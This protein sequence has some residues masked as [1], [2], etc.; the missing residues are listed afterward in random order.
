MANGAFVSA[1]IDKLADFEKRS[2]EAIIEFDSIIRKF[3]QINTDLRGKWKG[4]GSNAYKYETDHI[5]EN[6]GGI[7]D[8]LDAINNS[9]VK[10]TKDA[11]LNLDEQ[12]GAFN[13]NPSQGD[14]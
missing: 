12:L 1:D 9:A 6:I 3:N 11:Y 2:K 14:E 8:V 10:D 7:K 4:E 5:L 13:R